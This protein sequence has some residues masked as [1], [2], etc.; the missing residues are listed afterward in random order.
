M[1]VL[2]T[3]MFTQAG[4]HAVRRFAG[5]GYRVTAA[6]CHQLAYGAHS[7]HVHRRVRLPLPRR[8][9]VR[10]AWRLLEEL[11]QRHYD[12]FFP[13]FEET[14]FLAQYGDEIRRRTRT[15]LPARADLLGLHDKAAMLGAARAAGVRVPETVAPTSLADADQRL[16]RIDAP[17]VIK[18]RQSCNSGGLEFV[19]DP[20]RL[21]ARYR[22]LVKQH[23]L[24]EDRLPVVQRRVDGELLCSLELA[25][26]GRT[27]G[28]VLCRGNRMLPR[29][30]GTTTARETVHH[31]GCAE[32]SQRLIRALGWTGFVGF[33]YLVE[34]ESGRIFLIDSNPRCSVS[35][36][37]AWFGGSDWIGPWTEIARGVAARPAPACREGVKSKTHF[38][39]LLWMLGSY[40]D[41]SVD[42]QALAQQ[43]SRWWK[44]RGYHYDIMSA[45]DWR[46]TAMLYPYLLWQSRKLL[47]SRHDASQL[48]LYYN[49][50]PEL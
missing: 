44:D 27:V 2:V 31:P 28:Q 6:D 17:V 37:L 21:P 39:D 4:L 26:Q 33:D 11:E 19:D 23:R 9:P 43:R 42:A 46:P 50:A 13:S 16:R 14:Y 40:F 49:Q 7:R 18:L 22:S 30:G 41:G 32:A 48:F 10:Y 3:G 47:T 38:A 25:Q 36:A 29:R 35:L 12:Y 20:R 8:E 45:R 5:L 24:T 1:R 15:V 34:R